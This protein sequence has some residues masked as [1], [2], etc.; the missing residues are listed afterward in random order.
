[1]IYSH[2]PDEVDAY[3]AGAPKEIRGKLRQQKNASVSVCHVT[4]I[5]NG[6][7]ISGAF[8][9]ILKAQFSVM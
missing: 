3:I 6:R 1:V 9:A 5:R 2:G 4:I 7:L 8:F